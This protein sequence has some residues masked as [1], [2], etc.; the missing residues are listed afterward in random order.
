MA[1][2]D[3]HKHTIIISNFNRIIDGSEAVVTIQNLPTSQSY[4]QF[5]WEDSYQ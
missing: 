3:Q 5:A 4:L 1:V 2:V